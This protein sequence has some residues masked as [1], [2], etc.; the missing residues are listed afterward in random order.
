MGVENLKKEG[1]T[2]GV[3]VS[4]DIMLDAFNVFSAIAAQKTKLTDILP[5]KI[6]S[7]YCL[8]TIHRPV[9][10]DSR[11]NLSI[12]LEALGE[13]KTNIVW[14]VHPRNTDMIPRLK[15]PSNVFI[16]EPFSYYEM[17]VVLH[18]A[19][20][21]ITDSGG[22]QKEA[23][24]AKKPCVTIRTETEW[25]ETLHDNW[26]ILAKVDRSDILKALHTPTDPCSW[27]QL[28][29]DGNA[30]RKIAEKINA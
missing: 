20:K 10:T 30:G 6:A 1:I 3:D 15:I 16:F 28:Y 26:N 23:Y 17:M 11:E 21:V 7:E 29:G 24:W 14:P 9:N 25:I 27:S 18:G 2:K 22:L 5:E 4:G 13:V 8:L 19:K 12:I